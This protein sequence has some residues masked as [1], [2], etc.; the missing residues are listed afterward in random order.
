LLQQFFALNTRENHTN[1]KIKVIP[2]RFLFIQKQIKK[3]TSS[4]YKQFQ[5]S[6]IRDVSIRAYFSAGFFNQWASKTDF[7][8]MESK[9]IDLRKRK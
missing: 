5:N 1:K 9:N 3:V 8:E 2:I 6:R 7:R 4:L